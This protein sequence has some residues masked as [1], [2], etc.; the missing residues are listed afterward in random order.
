MLFVQYVLEWA[1]NAGL[2]I[3]NYIIFHLIYYFL[4]ILSYHMHFY[5]KILYYY[6]MNTLNFRIIT[7]ASL[8]SVP[9][10]LVISVILC[11]AMEVVMKVPSTNEKGRKNT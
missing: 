11:H 6:Y 7:K 2:V 3:V 1:Y 9:F 4:L 8:T 10:H 5:L